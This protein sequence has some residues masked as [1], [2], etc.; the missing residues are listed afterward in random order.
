M[1]EGCASGREAAAA[2]AAEQLARLLL[3]QLRS[4]SRHNL[5]P[6]DGLVVDF[7]DSGQ[8]QQ[9]QQHQQQRE[10]GEARLQE[11]AAGPVELQLVAGPEM[12]WPA[13]PLHV[14]GPALA[15]CLS[16]G[17]ALQQ[18]MGADGGAGCAGAEECSTSLQLPALP[19]L[20][21][22]MGHTSS[23]AHGQQ[24][25]SPGV[26]PAGA[27]ADS[28]AVAAAVGKGG[29]NKSPGRRDREGLFNA[30]LSELRPWGGGT[31]SPRA[32]ANTAAAA[33][34]L[35]SPNK[36]GPAGPAV[37]GLCG[38]SKTPTSPAAISGMRGSPISS[39]SSKTAKPAGNL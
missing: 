25:L 29:R 36:S 32:L 19:C 27:R 12:Q 16:S 22:N 10:E 13:A 24:Q 18:A 5:V 9:Q 33:G 11:G 2:G 4:Y 14:L 20:L 6:F 1:H 28:P 23:K 38:R 21:N 15:G 17:A 26:S 30:V 39:P 3:D 7:G 35:V 8:Y 34:A 31:G 37:S